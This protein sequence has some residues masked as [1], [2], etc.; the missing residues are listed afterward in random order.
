[1]MRWDALAGNGMP[2]WAVDMA[3]EAMGQQP[4]VGEFPAPVVSLLTIITWHHY[5]PSF[6]DIIAYHH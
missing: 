3:L 4:L 1:M 5:I 2:D 6:H